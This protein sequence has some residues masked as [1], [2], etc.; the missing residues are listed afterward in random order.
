M[1]IDDEDF[2]MVNASKLAE[3]GILR[4]DVRVG[5][6]VT[7][8]QLDSI[9]D[10]WEQ[11]Y[12]AS[13]NESN[14]SNV[15]NSLSVD[16]NKWTSMLRSFDGDVLPKHQSFELTNTRVK[17]SWND[18]PELDDISSPSNRRLKSHK[19]SLRSSLN[20]AMNEVVFKDRLTDDELEDKV[21][22]HFIFPMNFSFHLTR[23]L[24]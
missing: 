3:D 11:Q 23:L 2:S 20:E 6:V 1:D 13:S 24:F 19:D 7:D 16:S 4:C 22:F 15:Q 18:M 5:E 17:R 8:T 21:R 14:L 10:A 12:L 9:L